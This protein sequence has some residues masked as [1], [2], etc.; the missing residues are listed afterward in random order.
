MCSQSRSGEGRHESLRQVNAITPENVE[1]CFLYVEM[2]NTSARDIYIKEVAI[3]DRVSG[4]SFYLLSA[5]NEG[6]RI[7]SGDSIALKSELSQELVHEIQ[8]LWKESPGAAL[9]L[10][11]V[12]LTKTGS[13]FQ[14][15]LP[16]AL[17]Q[18]IK[19]T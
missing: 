7:A 15:R 13:R 14:V 11:Y 5:P 8:K 3:A 19:N 2:A 16:D 12:M 17:L 6:K 10:R 1:D 18:W 4:T 9:R